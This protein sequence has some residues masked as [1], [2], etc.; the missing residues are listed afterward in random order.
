[1][2]IPFDYAK[3][4]EILKKEFS[5]DKNGRLVRR[6]SSTNFCRKPQG[7][8]KYVL[9]GFTVSR[10]I[11]VSMYAHRVI[12]VLAHGDIPEGME[13]DHRDG[14]RH[15]NWLSNIRLATRE[16]NSQNKL[17]ATGVCKYPPSRRGMKM[18][19]ARLR[20]NGVVKFLG[21][22]LTRAEAEQ[23]YKKACDEL[24]THRREA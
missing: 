24:H 4:V 2:K 22:F 20:V 5:L 1:M 15:N 12:Y 14:V 9:T 8:V 19:Y 7:T 13:I 3:H 6:G 18:Y 16:Q 21:S 11:R 17:G 23:A 10:G